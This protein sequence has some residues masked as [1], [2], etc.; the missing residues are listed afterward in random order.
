MRWLF[1][2]RITQWHSDGSFE[3]GPIR[4]NI[5]DITDIVRAFEEAGI[6]SPKIEGAPPDRDVAMLH[7]RPLGD[8]ATTSAAEVYHL[9]IWGEVDEADQSRW[10]RLGLSIS[11]D[12]VRIDTVIAPPE[13]QQ[14]MANALAKIRG[15]AEHAPR[16]PL[17]PERKA[18]AT[19]LLLNTALLAALAAC[20][21]W[22]AF[23]W[24]SWPGRIMGAIVVALAFKAAMVRKVHLDRRFRVHPK[25]WWLDQKSRAELYRERANARRDFKVSL[26]S[27]TAGAVLGVIGTIL[28]ALLSGN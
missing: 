13:R 11:P 7:Y 26:V 4:L 23:S 20:W 25:R 8:L 3:S 9:Q 5:D 1:G 16:G 6:N 19:V 18:A 17:A 27:G 24:N 21:I 14:A 12:G 2:N 15:I 28:A 10:T 22:L